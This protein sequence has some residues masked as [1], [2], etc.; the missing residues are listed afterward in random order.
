MTRIT[1]T[2][3]AQT[4]A[5]AS[6]EDRVVAIRSGSGYQDWIPAF[7]RE[8]AAALLRLWAIDNA[9]PRAIRHAAMRGDLASSMVIGRT[10]FSEADLRQW[11]QA[12]RRPVNTDGVKA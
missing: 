3:T 2:N 1:T 6:A 10:K 4:E 8:E 9:T 7:G 11:I 5:G 12:M